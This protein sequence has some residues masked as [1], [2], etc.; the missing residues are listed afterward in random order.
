MTPLLCWHRAQHSNIENV[1]EAS[2]GPKRRRRRSAV[3][4]QST[5]TEKETSN[6]T[7]VDAAADQLRPL[8]SIT[9]L[10]EVAAA[11]DAAAG[12]G[13]PAK[14]PRGRPPRAAKT[15]AAPVAG[16]AAAAAAAPPS[17]AALISTEAAGAAGPAGDEP[18]GRVPAVSAGASSGKAKGRSSS[19]SSSGPSRAMEQ[20]L[21]GQGFR[22]VAGV[23]EA[24]RGPL[25]GPVVAAA[26]VLPPGQC[27]C[28]SES[29]SCNLG[30]MN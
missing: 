14:R 18:V 27:W 28:I 8:G 25:A 2:D 21:W 20:R 26:A 24:G 11:G 29:C 5:G 10:R 19:K 30:V 17:P 15:A 13:P 12:A 7:D 22:A 3:T 9:N 6:Q 1:A 16:A 23:D 4:R